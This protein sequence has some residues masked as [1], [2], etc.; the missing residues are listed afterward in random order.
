MGGLDRWSSDETPVAG[1]QPENSAVTRA[2][3]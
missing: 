2:M 1:D 3:H